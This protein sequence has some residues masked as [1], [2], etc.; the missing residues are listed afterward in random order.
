[1]ELHETMQAFVLHENMFAKW[2]RRKNGKIDDKMENITSGWFFC[3]G[4]NISPWF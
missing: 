2:Q 4:F 3:I 1:M